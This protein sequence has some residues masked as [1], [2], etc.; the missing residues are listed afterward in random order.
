[1][2]M[3]IR[4]SRAVFFA[5]TTVNLD[6]DAETLAEVGIAC[7]NKVRVLGIEPRVAMLSF[8]NFGSTRHP[9][10]RKVSDAVELVRE[11]RP[12]IMIDGEMQA[13]FALDPRRR[14]EHFPFS[15]LEGDAN[16]LVFPSLEAANIAFKLVQYL[17]DA[18]V[19]GPILLGLRKPVTV[20]MRGAS[21]EDI[22]RMTAITL[23][24]RA[25]V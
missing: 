17:S 15:T 12:D 18:A 20:M 21:A 16:V 11:R 9:L 1:M 3:I 14:G 6:P 7:A 8:S 25:E 2:H 22:I 13:S 24:D 23:V 10:T 19:V 5:D 4:G